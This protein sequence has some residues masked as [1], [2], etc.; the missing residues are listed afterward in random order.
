MTNK[1]KRKGYRIENNLVKLLKKK[2]LSARRQPMS[3]ALQ[4]FPHDIQI[5]NPSINV[6][7][8]GRK[9]GVGF[10]TLKRWKQGA[11]ALFLHEDFGETLVC[12]NLNLFI[13]ILL[14]HKEYRMPYEQSIKEKT[15]YE[16]S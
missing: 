1:S 11:D 8:K 13:D 4:D 14:N 9:G 12:I 7:V 16:D 15:R 2:G 10:K 3:G 6:E 5:N